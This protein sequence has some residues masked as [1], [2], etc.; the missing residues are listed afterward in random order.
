MFILAGYSSRLWK[1]P[2]GC[3]LFEAFLCRAEISLN[4]FSYLVGHLLGNRSHLSRLSLIK[5]AELPAL[6]FG[7]VPGIRIMEWGFIGGLR[8]F[9]KEK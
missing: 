9:E 5:A 8:L 3:F 2:D 7:N 4:R 1:C 6:K